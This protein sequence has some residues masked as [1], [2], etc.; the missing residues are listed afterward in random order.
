M[1]V[2]WP[3]APFTAHVPLRYSFG[4]YVEVDGMTTV[5]QWA[6]RPL[7]VVWGIE[8][9]PPVGSILYEV[10]TPNLICDI[11]LNRKYEVVI[12]HLLEVALLPF[13]S[14]HECNLVF[15]ELYE[16]IRPREIGQ[17]G[18]GMLFWIADDVRHSGL[19]PT[20]VDLRVTGLASGRTDVCG[21]FGAQ[22]GGWHLAERAGMQPREIQNQGG[23]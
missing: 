21:R 1:L 10:G 2:T 3:V 5:T 20:L 23:N 9:R 8:R 19:L 15:G 18:I 11:P 14:V 12:A 4:F 6:G 7:H 13:A 17:D 22:P 16:R